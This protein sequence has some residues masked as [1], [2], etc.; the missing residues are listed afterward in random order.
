MRA[1]D[2]VVLEWRGIMRRR[3]NS[4]THLYIYIYYFVIRREGGR[5]GSEGE[6]GR[7]EMLT[8]F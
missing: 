7:W 4:F 3:P 6:G 2:E 1:R 5:R 8:K